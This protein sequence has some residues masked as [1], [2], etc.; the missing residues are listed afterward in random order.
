MSIQCAIQE[1]VTEFVFKAVNN[2]LNDG[3]G[4]D[5][6]GRAKNASERERMRTTKS[7]CGQE[8]TN[9]GENERTRA[10]RMRGIDSKREQNRA[11]SEQ[12]DQ[13]CSKARG[14]VRP[15]G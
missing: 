14:L 2:C 5:G 3:K 11:K 6:K 15:G 7:E 13:Y 9:K 4:H 10:K 8:R 12:A 1:N